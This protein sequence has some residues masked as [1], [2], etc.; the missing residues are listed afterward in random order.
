MAVHEAMQYTAAILF[1]TGLMMTAVVSGE[2]H[3]KW[4]GI[5]GTSGVVL[6]AVSIVLLIASVWLQVQV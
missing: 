2:W 5:I 4:T 6:M 3:T 1:L